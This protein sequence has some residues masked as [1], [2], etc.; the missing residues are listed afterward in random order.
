MRLATLLVGGLVE[1][2]GPTGLQL[3][4]PLTDYQGTFKIYTDTC[5]GVPVHSYIIA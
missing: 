3:V 1:S 5:P 4:T 2:P